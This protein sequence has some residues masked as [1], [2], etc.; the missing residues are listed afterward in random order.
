MA[1]V[2]LLA[3]SSAAGGN[4]PADITG[5]GQVDGADLS[6]LL[7]GW[8]LGGISDITGDGV[9]N[10]TDL[11]VLLGSWGLCPE[12]P[13]EISVS[14]GAAALSFTEGGSVGVAFTIEVDGVGDAAVVLEVGDVHALQVRRQ[15]IAG[16]QALAEAVPVHRLDERV[17]RR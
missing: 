11:G 16:E 3:G 10:G 15:P 1:A 6:V 5:D 17:P 9:T 7:G 4:C 12:A 2:G 13:V 8:G 14:A